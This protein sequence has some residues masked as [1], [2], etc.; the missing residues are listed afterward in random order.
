[1]KQSLNVCIKVFK[2]R[3]KNAYFSWIMYYNEYVKRCCY[4]TK[5]QKE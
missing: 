2:T 4:T 5:E 1:M 3:F